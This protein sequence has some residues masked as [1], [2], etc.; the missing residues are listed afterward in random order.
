[1]TGCSEEA[2]GDAAQGETT[3]RPA[4]VVEEE[5]RGDAPRPPLRTAQPGEKVGLNLVEN[6]DFETGD[7]SPTKLAGWTEVDGLTTFFVRDSAR[8]RMLKIDTD[9]NLT[10]ADTRWKEM[11]KPAA[12]RSKAAPKGPTKAPYYDTVGGTTGAKIYSDYIRVEPGMRYRIKADVM[13]TGPTVKIFVKG[14]AKLSGGF[15]KY[16]QCY[17]NVTTATGRWKTWERTFNPT[18]GSLKVT[19]IRVM[20]YAYWPVGQAFI[21]NVRVER[22]GPDETKAAAP[23]KNLL[24]GGDFTKKLDPWKAEGDAGLLL[25]G[26]EGGCG[27]VGPGGALV[28]GSVEVEEEREYVLRARV[29]PDRAVLAVTVEGLVALGGERHVLFTKK[30]TAPPGTGDW[31]DIEIPFHPTAET[32]QVMEVRV[33]FEV[34]AKKGSALV[35]DVSIEVKPPAGKDPE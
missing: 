34:A 6:G 11:E 28:S 33:R 4:R 35:D 5:R 30:E 14:Y 25:R 16:Y 18:A 21:D 31:L 15:R 23:G 17:K 27:R 24:R 20:P 3:K 29:Q 1:V 13:S 22:V 2:G 7:G 32:P 12:D 19:H 26:S 8:G 9:V 10:E